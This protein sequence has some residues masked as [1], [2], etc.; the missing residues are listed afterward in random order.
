[1]FG[2]NGFYYKDT[3]SFKN[4]GIS[5]NFQVQFYIR[6]ISK[7]GKKFVVTKDQNSSLNLVRSSYRLIVQYNESLPFDI[8]TILDVI[9]NDVDIKGW[10]DDKDDILKMETEKQLYPKFGLL[11]IDFEV[12]IETVNICIPCN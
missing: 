9:S 11:S 12:C 7:G 2:V 4:G 6:P 10:N 1:M 5:D 8:S 3:L